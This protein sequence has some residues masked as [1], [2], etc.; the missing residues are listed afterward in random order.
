MLSPVSWLEDGTPHSLHFDDVYRSTGVDGRGWLEQA[1]HVF[2][3]GCGLL[4]GD[5][6]SPALW[7]DRES[8]QLLETGFGLG[9]NFLATWRAWRD[10]P[11]RPQRLFFTSIESTPVSA[12]DIRRSARPFPE[13]Q[14]LAEQLAGQWQAMLPGVHRL[15]FEG[16]RVQL[17]LAIGLAQDLLPTLDSAVDSIVLDGF[18]PQLNPELWELPLLRA[19]ARLSRPGTRLATWTIARALRDGLVAAGFTVEKAPGLPPSRPQTGQTLPG[20]SGS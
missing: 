12:D 2:L 17:T 14:A 11:Q 15:V 1:R 13:L 6:G 20:C 16:G 10:D 7:S 4:R 19:V 5:D 9:L 3:A 18:S 8:W